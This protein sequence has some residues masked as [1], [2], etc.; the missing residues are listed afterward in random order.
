MTTAEPVEICLPKTC[1]DIRTFLASK[2]LER[3]Y[4]PINADLYIGKPACV[5]F[6][7]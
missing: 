2:R 1:F 7:K 5:K 3:G 4:P 6:I